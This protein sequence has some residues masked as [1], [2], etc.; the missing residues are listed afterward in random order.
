M[1]KPSYQLTPYQSGSFREI[2][3]ISWP[4]MLSFLSISVMMF[5]DRIMLSHYSVEAL[6]AAAHSGMAVFVFLV[7]AI[8]IA[9]MAEVFVGRANGEGSFEQTGKAA[10][11]M[12]WF[13]FL[14]TPLFILIAFGASPILFYKT[15]NEVLEKKFFTLL[16]CFAPFFCSTVSLTGFFIGLGRVTIVTWCTFI[17]NIVNIGLDVVLI[18]GWGKIPAMG[19]AGAA[20]ATGFAQ[21]FQT[22]FL[23]TVFFSAKYRTVYGTTRWA[24][25]KTL[26]WNSLKIGVPS[27]LN[28]LMEMVSHLV[29]LR[30]MIIS[31][32]V[33][34]TI[35][36]FAQSII[37]LLN[38]LTEGLAKAVTT[39]VA[40][41][42]GGKVFAP[43]GNVLR[44]AFS[45]HFLFFMGV[46]SILYFF[47]ESVMSM[48][49]SEKDAY[50]LEDQTF[51][52]TARTTCIWLCLFFLFDGISRIFVGHLTA[53]EDT[54]FVL[55]IGLVTNWFFYIV[56]VFVVVMIY[57]G[58]GDQAWCVT[59]AYSVLN[60]ALYGWRYLSKKWQATSLPQAA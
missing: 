49:F 34:I 47:P 2:W 52:Q 9:A 3:A 50:L 57:N 7:P 15:G 18:F 59:M 55:Y 60:S 8:A 23:F 29:F 22:I 20:I 58:S 51:V 24:F 12:I 6:N 48:F 38:F 11:Q 30:L 28:L 17:A 25:D 31:G 39:I 44:A 16:L 27:G 35:T 40:N 37:F 4:L 56:P 19:I 1:I 54:K 21:V 36:A 26:F 32:G 41:L 33:A 42:I 53:A 46:F 45:L 10:W 13:S 14:A 5:A 43:I